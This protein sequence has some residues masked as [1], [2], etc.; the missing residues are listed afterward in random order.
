MQP[1]DSEAP[2]HPSRCLDQ[3]ASVDLRLGACPEVRTV[4]R[5]FFVC[6]EE[7]VKLFSLLCGEPTEVLKDGG[8]LWGGSGRPHGQL[9]SG[10]IAVC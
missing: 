9:S 10:C 2:L 8:G 6:N 7:H 5:G 3:V 4:W 1:I